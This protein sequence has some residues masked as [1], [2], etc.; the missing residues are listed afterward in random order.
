M[1]ALGTLWIVA[2]MLL[3]NADVLARELAGR[4]LR[5]VAEIVS[6]SIVGI[7]FLELPSALWNG[8]LIRNDALLRRL[9]ARRPRLARGLERAFAATGAF[10]FTL[11]AVA[12]AGFAV[13]AVR[14]D[15]YVGALGDFTAPTW[16]IR[17]ILVLGSAATAAGFAALALGSGAAGAGDRGGPRGE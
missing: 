3:I 9:S 16:P 17:A 5:G 4:P 10:V 11:L 7:V 2:L 13:K 14:V 8:R 15:E 6:L 12:G 1:N